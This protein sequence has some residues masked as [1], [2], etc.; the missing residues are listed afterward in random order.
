MLQA[1][2]RESHIVL[3]NIGAPGF[4]WEVCSFCDSGDKNTLIDYRV[5]RAQVQS[6]ADH[7]IIW[8]EREVVWKS[9][10]MAANLC[11]PST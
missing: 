2:A 9:D 10:Y 3:K 11:P 6:L 4:D 1:L 5:L 8:I 7:G